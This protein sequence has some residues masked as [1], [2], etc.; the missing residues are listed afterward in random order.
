MSATDTA[1]SSDYAAGYAAAMARVRTIIEAGRRLGVPEMAMAMVEV[2]LTP[3]AAIVV[4]R[5]AS[6]VPAD[7]HEAADARH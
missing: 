1:P 3:E 7:Q 6:T 2:E 4:M 5:K